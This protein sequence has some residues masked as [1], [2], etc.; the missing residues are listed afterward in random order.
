MGTTEARGQLGQKSK[1][2]SAEGAHQL[3]FLT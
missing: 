1:L 2:A 3:P